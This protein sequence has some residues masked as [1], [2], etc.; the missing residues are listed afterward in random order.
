MQPQHDY[1]Y[2][3]S[4]NEHPG[5]R[6]TAAA[7]ILGVCLLLVACVWIF[8]QTILDYSRA[9]QYQPS[10]AVASIVQRTAMSDQGRFLFY[11]SNPEI[12]GSPQFTTECPIKTE[13][14]STILGCYAAQRIYVYDVIN[15]ELDGIKDVTAAHE[16]LHAAYERLSGPERARVDRLTETEY[17][18]LKSDQAFAARVKLYDTIEPDQRANELHS[19][20]GTEIGTVS[21]ELEQYYGRYFKD[22]SKV[23]ELQRKYSTVFAELKQKSDALV[24]YLNDLANKINAEKAEY[25]TRVDALNLKVSRFNADAKAGDLTTQQFVSQRRALLA[26]S[27]ELEALRTTIN[28]RVTQYESKKSEYLAI[29]AH[30]DELNR[31]ID[32]KLAPVPAL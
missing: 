18:R 9:F 7:V 30:T 17:N 11:A 12:L 26:E 10:S 14:T 3:P 15:S 2:A 8:R 1:T 5:G 29:A 22:R 32:S 28:D 23:V 25:N 19:I 31:S 27:D 21:Q 13:K 16:M 24:A 6:H 4:A 20:I